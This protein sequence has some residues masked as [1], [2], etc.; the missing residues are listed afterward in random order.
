MI[1][2]DVSLRIFCLEARIKAGSDF[3]HGGSTLKSAAMF[4]SCHQDEAELKAL[5]LLEAKMI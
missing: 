5:K 3:R 2:N 4:V 1:L